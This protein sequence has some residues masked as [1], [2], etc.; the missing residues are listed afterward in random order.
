MRAFALSLIVSVLWIPTAVTQD[1]SATQPYDVADAYK[2]Y[3]LLLPHEESY[4][5]A[6]DTLMIQEETVSHVSPVGACL[7]PEVWNKFKDA[8]A[9]FNRVQKKWLLQRHF[10]IEKSYKLVSSDVIRTLPD[11]PQSASALVFMS[12]VGFN[13]EKTRAI[14]YMGSQ[15]GGLC[16]SATFHLLEKVHGNWTEARVAGCTAES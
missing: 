2:I 8:I 14:V 11:Q 10:E 7:T 4:G 15:C 5:F 1:S 9:G 3:S 13:R 12:A 6:K 16:G